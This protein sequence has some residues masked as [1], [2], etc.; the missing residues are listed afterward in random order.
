MTHSDRNARLIELLVDNAT[1]GLAPE[2]HTELEQYGSEGRSPSEADLFEL[3]AAAADLAFYEQAQVGM[4]SGLRDRLLVSA[5]REMDRNPSKRQESPASQSPIKVER[6][7]NGAATPR[8]RE[9]VSFLV[10]AACLVILL[11]N[12]DRIMEPTSKANGTSPAVAQA[13][14]VSPQQEYQQL[15]AELGQA[16]NRPIWSRGPNDTDE[17]GLGASGDLVWDQLS[18]RGVM[19]FKDLPVNDPSQEQ[20]QLWIFESGDQ[21]HPIDG[22]VFNITKSDEYIPIH[23]KIGVGNEPVLF[24]VTIEKPGGVVVSDRSRLPL[25]TAAPASLP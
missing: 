12:L 7:P 18:Q 14:S 20:Y 19:R 2:E 25:W 21:A 10:A 11:V 15:G 1:V 16:Y 23:A 24:A 8:W 17:T 22:G 4:P 5:G 9:V 3:A 6:R 13:T